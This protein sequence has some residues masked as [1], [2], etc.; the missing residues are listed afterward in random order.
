MATLT[1]HYINR[2]I[3]CMQLYHLMQTAVSVVWSLEVVGYSRAAIA[4]DTIIETSVGTLLCS[5]VRN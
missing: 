1:V 4:P 2:K 5:S 3:I